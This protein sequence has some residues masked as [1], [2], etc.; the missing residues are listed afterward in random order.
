MGKK[1]EP[2]V[3]ITAAWGQQN[4]K[5]EKDWFREIGAW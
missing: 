1:L 2:E 5:L 4:T 3:W